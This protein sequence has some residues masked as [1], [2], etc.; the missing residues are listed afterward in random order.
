MTGEYVG[1]LELA[2]E[3]T[4]HSELADER[5][6][7]SELADEH[8]G[9]LE[10]ADS[11]DDYMQIGESTAIES[12]GSF[13]KVI[14]AIFGD[15]YLR[16]PTDEDTTRLLA[17]SKQRR[18]PGILPGDL[19]DINVLERSSV[20]SQ[21]VEGHGPTVNYIVNGHEYTMGYYLADAFLPMG[22]DEPSVGYSSFLQFIEFGVAGEDVVGLE[23]FEYIDFFH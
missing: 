11:V 20:F 23:F 22:L 14:V 3:H 1:Y 12:L 6:G 9:H 16:S 5:A 10:M 4:G 7:H 2:D 19:N 8:A 21:V 17:I 18:F 13:T 15:E